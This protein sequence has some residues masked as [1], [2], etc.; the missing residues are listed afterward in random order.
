MFL[1]AISRERTLTENTSACHLRKNTASVDSPATIEMFRNL[2]GKPGQRLVTHS[3][4]PQP[5]AGLY[6]RGVQQTSNAGVDL[7]HPLKELDL[8]YDSWN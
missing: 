7:L 1:R 4:P 2:W 3:V 8:S 5:F 6:P